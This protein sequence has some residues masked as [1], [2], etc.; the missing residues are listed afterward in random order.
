MTTKTK[1][2]IAREFLILLFGT[3]L[4]FVILFA[5]TM[6]HERNSD[7]QWEIKSELK[8]IGNSEQIPYR[9]KTFFYIN[10][11]L[12]NEYNQMEDAS[13]FISDYQDPDFATEIYDWIRKKGQISITEE[14]FIAKVN[15]DKESEKYWNKIKPKVNEL[16]SELKEKRNSVFD[17]YVDDDSVFG[18][19]FFLFCIMFL[20]R[21]L[22]YATKWSIK[23]LKSNE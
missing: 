7:R 13:S 17:G 9:L 16:K 2:I 18:L 19:A 6:L 8:E 20:L 21:Y 14:S 11:E 12:L 1:K 5:W 10:N 22:I 15:A 23:Q 4:Y 3:I